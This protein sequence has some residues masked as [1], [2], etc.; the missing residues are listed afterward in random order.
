[1]LLKYLFS[2]L[3]TPSH[4]PSRTRHGL[5]HVLN[6]IALQRFE[7]VHGQRQLVV[8]RDRDWR[9]DTKQWAEK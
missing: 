6:V 3:V 7:G 4:I 8:V 5:A 1:M 9:R 2:S